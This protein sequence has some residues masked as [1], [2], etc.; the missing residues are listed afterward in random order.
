MFKEL[1]KKAKENEERWEKID[2]LIK[3]IE[4]VS[5]DNHVRRDYL[6]NGITISNILYPMIQL[7]L[8]LAEQ[9]RPIS[10]ASQDVEKATKEIG[11]LLGS[12]SSMIPKK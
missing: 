9:I 2:E 6:D 12:L 11:N 3:D 7:L 4:F 5:A 10:S 8:L 1:Q